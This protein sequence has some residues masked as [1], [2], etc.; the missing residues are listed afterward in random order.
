MIDDADLLKLTQENIRFLIGQ[1]ISFL[2]TAANTCMFWWA[3]AVVACGAL[4]RGI[5][6]R[7]NKIADK[8]ITVV[9]LVGATGFI[10][11]VSLLVFGTWLIPY[12]YLTQTQ[13]EITNLANRL[14]ITK[15]ENIKPQ[16][17]S[18]VQNEQN[19]LQNQE[20]PVDFFK[21]EIDTFWYAMYIGI[22]SFILILIAWCICTAY[23]H[24]DAK[25]RNTLVQPL[26]ATA[27][28]INENLSNL[29]NSLNDLLTQKDKN[30]KAI[31]DFIGNLAAFKEGL[32]KIEETLKQL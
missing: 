4:L 22:T 30:H 11:I 29:A 18:Q 3:T 9:R 28:S 24:V 15:L 6:K 26:Q 31:Q 27:V 13:T 21:R 10:F 7:R 1:K 5:W 16:D 19:K 32:S 17:A 20:K 14:A 12:Y 23:L 25:N 2:N 8:G